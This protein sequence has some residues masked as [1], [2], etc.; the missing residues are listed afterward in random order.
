L[1]A[2]ALAML[3]VRPDGFYIDAT[4]GRGGHARE[5]VTRLGPQGMLLAI[6]RDPEAVTHGR[7]L[8]AGDSRVIV[9][10]AS[11]S[12]LTA[13]SCG[14]GRAA[15]GVLIDLGVSSPQLDTA[16]R[17]F[18]FLREGPLDMRMDP[19]RG[20]TAAAW[21]AAVSERDLAQ[22]IAR[23]GEDRFARRIARAIV[24]AR[25]QAPIGTTA[26][27]AA[28]V[29][30]AVPTREPGKHPA[31]R[32][33][34]AIRMHINRELEELESVL[35]QAMA[36]LA[37]GGRL[38]VISFHSLEDRAVKRFM[39]D[40][41]QDDAAWAG[42]PQ[43]PPHARAKLQRLGKAVFPSA[44]EIGRNPRARSAVLRAALRR[45]A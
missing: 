36:A 27:L 40:Q 7:A 21:L 2:E 26:A 25:A 6:D 33:F 16:A 44:E 19:T 4:L 5:I 12:G 18:S 14:L 22:V 28:V 20:S 3:D 15:S 32:T 13:L 38:V 39:R 31:T 29:A 30:A 1:C 41:S 42:L 10:H 24:A 35:P 34:Q 43:M 8:F 45:A 9:E 37:P 11:F 17:G 23:Y